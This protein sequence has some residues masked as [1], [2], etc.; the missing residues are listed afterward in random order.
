[1]SDASRYRVAILYYGDPANR[2]PTPETSK[3]P[4]VFPALAAVG[5][6]ARPVVYNDDYCDDVR[7]QLMQMDGVLVWVNP[8][9][10]GRDQSVLDTLLRDVAAAGIFVSAHP[11][12]ILKL[13]TKDVLYTTRAI[14][15]GSD[16]HSYPTID[17]MRRELAKRLAAGEVR[18]LKQYRGN[19]GSGVWKVE[20]ATDAKVAAAG[21]MP[22]F[23]RHAKRGCVEE[24]IS[25]NE[26]LTRCEPYFAGG[27]RM[28]DQVYQRRLS[29]GM[30]RCY[31]V[32]DKVGGFGHQAINALCPAPAGAPREA[33]PQPTRRIYH[34]PSLPEFQALKRQLEEEW[35][36]ALQRLLDIT[37]EQLPILWDC[38]FMLGPKSDLGDDTYVLCEINVSSVSPFPDAALP[39]VADATLARMQAAA[40][41]R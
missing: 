21:E 11:D 41:R 30:I 8:I 24:K 18:V 32:H 37:K 31:L 39:L 22:V 12:V 29:E 40:R 5:I 9:E 23:A 15:W 27:G 2:D 26:F 20:R 38:D 1:M 19:G 25:F 28:I 17:E 3:V 4:K 13:G 34:P 35:V 6:D 10:D 36:P 16:T 14:G 33:A 7:R